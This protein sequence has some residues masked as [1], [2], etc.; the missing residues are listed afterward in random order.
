MMKIK[1]N[2]KNLKRNQN[3]KSKLSK[4]SEN[5]V[6]KIYIY[7]FLMSFELLSGVF[8]PFY[9]YW[10]NVD[11]FGAML[12]QSYFTIV[13]L[14]LEIPC[15]AISDYF[16]KKLSLFLGGF[17]GVIGTVMYSVYQNIFLF[18][19]AET[20][21]AFSF[22]LVSGTDQAILYDILNK[23]EKQD[24]I[25]K[26]MS[27]LNSFIFIGSGIS[28][29]IGSL[30]GKYISLQF[31]M[32]SMA[33]PFL[34]ATLIAISIN[35]PEQKIKINK[36]EDKYSDVVW[37]GIG[38]LR[39]NKILRILTFEFIFIDTIV[40]FN[41]LTYQPY[42]EQINVPLEFFG[43]IH[44]LMTLCQVIFTYVLP[45]IVVKIHKKK[46]LL[47]FYTIIAGILFILM[48]LI[49]YPLISI[50]LV[51]LFSGFGFSRNILFVKGINYQIKTKN[52]ATVLSTINMLNNIL[53]VIL[54]PLIGLMLI[55]NLTIIYI[56]L[57]STIIFFALFSKLKNEY[58]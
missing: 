50:C 12:F 56:I 28:A 6:I 42:M 35:E 58:L 17:M 43:L 37:S 7:R 4:E 33:I 44:G 5:E 1:N 40:I 8:I 9:Y 16:G 18:I 22:A 25:S 57:G 46:R 23:E 19:I 45:K 48:A 34:L 41:F 38:E 32:F 53:Q 29:P 47:T 10:V 20:I 54:F 27:V 21:L 11:F 24:D 31:V 13:I 3:D 49:K 36:E 15:G 51:L 14:L 2:K 26:K 39:K 30:I 52:R 55:S